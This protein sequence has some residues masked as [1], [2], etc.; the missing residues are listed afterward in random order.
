MKNLLIPIIL[1][2]LLLA[3][4]GQS[5]EEQRRISKAERQRLKT[6]DSLALK[7]AVLPTL[8]CLPLYLAKDKRW[9][10]TLDVDVRLRRFTAQMDCDTAL[11]GKSVEGMV[12]DLVRAERIRREGTAL[13]YL[14][15]TNAYWLLITNRKARIKKVDQLGDKMV[16]MARYSVTDHLTDKALKGV[17]TSS[18]VFR[19]QVNDVNVRLAM[20][21]NNEMDAMWLTEPQAALARQA[22]NPVISDSRSFRHSYGAIVFRTDAV[23]DSRRKSQ[24]AKF[25]KAYNR[26]CDS[27]TQRGLL[28]YSDVLEKY[29]KLTAADVKALPKLKFTN[30]QK[31][32]EADLADCRQTTR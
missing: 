3:S 17:K 8:D 2:S 14:T 32:K 21:L 24:M 25:I 28:P 19:I 9:F 6:E 23:G 12:T 5:V 13:T 1:L 11:L 7:V 30:V 29:Y 20:L 15:S 27:L 22:G 18:M 26:A 16:A 31:P 4:C 10:D